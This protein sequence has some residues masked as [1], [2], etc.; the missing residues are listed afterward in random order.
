MTL[1]LKVKWTF[2]LA[3][4]APVITANAILNIKASEWML[5]I[6]EEVKNVNNN[7]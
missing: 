7:R 2:V 4:A 3:V 1:W 6:T 5:K